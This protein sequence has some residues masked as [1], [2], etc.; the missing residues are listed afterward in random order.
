MTASQ[1]PPGRLLG[2]LWLAAMLSSAGGAQ[3]EGQGPRR[4][5]TRQALVNL[6]RLGWLADEDLS[7]ELASRRLDFA[8]TPEVE[9]DLRAAGATD[10]VL[11]AARSVPAAR[12][13]GP[14]PEGTLPLSKE[15]VIALLKSGQTADAVEAQISARG[16]A[17]MV[18]RQTSDEILA[19][20]GSRSLLGTASVTRKGAAVFD[21]LLDAAVAA[22]SANSTTHAEQLLEQAA[23]IRPENAVVH[24]LLGHSRFHFTADPALAAKEVEAAIRLGGWVSFRM[25]HLHSL[26]EG[27]TGMLFVSLSGIAYRADR[28][29]HSFELRRP[30][31]IEAHALSRKAGFDSVGGNLVTLIGSWLHLTLEPLVGGARGMDFTLLGGLRGPSWYEAVANTINAKGE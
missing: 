19:A 6:V 26:S 24:S 15:E 3:V 16:A 11:D 9:R 23:S 28:G 31:L 10:S 5:L 27:C 8:V 29:S 4:P 30:A 14:T 20:G 2:A 17:F 7:S 12:H 1:R 18:S 22:A 13:G 25:R 21:D